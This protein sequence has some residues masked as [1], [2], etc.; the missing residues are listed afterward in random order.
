MKKITFLI[1]LGI[2][3][4]FAQHTSAPIAEVSK[5]RIGVQGG[6]GYQLAKIAEDTPPVLMDYSKN[7]KSGSTLS[8]DASYFLNDTWG[9]GLKYSRFGTKES[10]NNLRFDYFD[11]SFGYGGVSDQIAVNFI[12]PSFLT[13]Y[14]FFNPKHSLIASLSLGYMSY[15]N[16]AVLDNQDYSLKGS[17][18]GSALD[19][20]YDYSISKNIIIGALASVSGGSLSKISVDNGIS[21]NTVDFEDDSLQSLARLDISAG[22]RFKI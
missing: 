1:L 18:L 3:P 10:M 21:K 16:N 8:L 5:F 14:D 22:L 11:G 6:Y 15:H 12:G 13:R 9:L 4:L 20:G 19:L 7:L 2:L 17:T